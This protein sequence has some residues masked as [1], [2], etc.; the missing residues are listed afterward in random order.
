MLHIKNTYKYVYGEKEGWPKY[1]K[2][3]WGLYFPA[4]E[5]RGVKGIFIQEIFY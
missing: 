3:K 5:G 2:E 4:A 1:H